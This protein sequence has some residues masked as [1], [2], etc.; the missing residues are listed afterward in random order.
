M[1]GPLAAPGTKAPAVTVVTQTRVEPNKAEEF[2]QWQQKISEAVAAQPGFIKEIVMPPSPPAQVDWVILQRFASREAALAWLRSSERQRLM[3]EAQPMLLGQD[4]VHLVNDAESGVLPAP[5]SAVISTRIKPGQEDAYRQWERKITAAQARTPGFQGF[6]FEPPVPGVQ[7][8]WLTILRFDSEANLQTWLESPERKALLE[9][10]QVF[11][12]EYHTRI[13]RTGFDQWFEVG[14]A[15]AG[16]PPPPA[17]KQNMIVLL[18]L[19]PVVFLIT[20]WFEHPFLVGQLKMSHWSALFVDNVVSVILL[21]LVV[22]W[23]SRRFDWWLRPAGRD[24]NRDLVGVALVLSFYALCLLA[25]WQYELH[26][27]RPW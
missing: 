12:D 24:L 7:D 4:D 21:S 19:Y 1:T 27:W 18:M 3:A 20:A 14:G 25:F 5:V 15:G 11:T 23:A 13:V 16:A 8:D 17:W 2:A 9:E 22:P 10:A 26:V 6:R